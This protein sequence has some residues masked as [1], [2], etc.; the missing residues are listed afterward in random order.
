MSTSDPIIT[1]TIHEDIHT[2]AVETRHGFE[3]MAGTA[4]PSGVIVG[5]AVTK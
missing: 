5:P 4:N 1:Y 3:S 2:I